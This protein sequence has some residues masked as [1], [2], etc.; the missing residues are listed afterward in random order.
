LIGYVSR[1][2]LA[3]FMMIGD[4]GQAAEAG[5]WQRRRA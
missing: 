3:E 5:P 1:E 4:A 2:N